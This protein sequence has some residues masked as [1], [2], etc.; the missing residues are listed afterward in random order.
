MPSSCRADACEPSWTPSANQTPASRRAKRAAKSD[1][2]SPQGEQAT[3]Q[4]SLDKRSRSSMRHAP[5][6]L[7]DAAS[8]RPPRQE[9]RATSA[10]P[11]EKIISIENRRRRVAEWLVMKDE[12][13]QPARLREH[14]ERQAESVIAVRQRRRIL[15]DAGS[16]ASPPSEKIRRAGPQSNALDL[17]NQ[18]RRTHVSKG[19]H[20]RRAVAS[21]PSSTRSSRALNANRATAPPNADIDKGFQDLVALQERSTATRQYSPRDAASAGKNR[22]PT[23]TADHQTGSTRA[24]EAYR[25]T[26][27]R[28]AA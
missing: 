28:G 1:I 13:P 8:T 2:E 6:N 10:R 12:P 9:L 5:G 23:D 19:R 27:D 14:A 11:E 21:S 15:A 16:R 25:D 18:K 22:G 24:H 17:D 7:S 3:P 4:H 20:P 26:R